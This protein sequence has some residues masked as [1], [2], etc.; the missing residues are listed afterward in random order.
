MTFKPKAE[1]LVGVGCMKKVF[2]AERTVFSKARKQEPS[3]VEEFKEISLVVVK[4]REMVNETRSKQRT[5]S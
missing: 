3:I 1:Y 4:R 2:R 5:R